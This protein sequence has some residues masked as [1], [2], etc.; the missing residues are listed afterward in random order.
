VELY[1]LFDE[2]IRELA[3]VLWGRD[4]SSLT[5]QS[6]PAG[7][8][9][10]IDEQFQGRT[11]LSI[12]YLLPGSRELRLQ[13]S[14]YLP[15]SRT[16]ELSPYTEGVENISLSPRPREEFFLD[17]IPP[18]AAVYRGS[19]WL[20]TTPLGVEKPDELSRL[21][22]RRGGYLDFPLYLPPAVEE[23]VSAGLK[24]DSFDPGE[25]QRRRR[26]Q[27]Y[28]AF[29]AF[30][31]SVPFPLFLG[32]YRGDYLAIGEDIS[33]LTYGYVGTF[34]LSSALFVNLLVRLV[35]YLQEAD[36]KA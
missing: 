36:R 10:W 25:L 20:G 23:S 11:P 16:I 30:A 1:A 35:R 33:A 29:G 27:L 32:G 5:V 15:V 2:L 31:L 17:S 28:R 14:G 22:L 24:P 21:L 26:D 3:T 7:A 19:E 34:A 4:W 8:S 9:V 13:V 18:G 6:V 12:P